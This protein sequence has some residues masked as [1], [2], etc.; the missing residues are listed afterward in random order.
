MKRFQ[1]GASV[2]EYAIL[3][4][5]VAI[6][7]LVGVSHMGS[8]TRGIFIAVNS[9]LPDLLP[10]SS[11]APTPPPAEEAVVDP[12]P[13]KSDFYRIAASGAPAYH[14]GIGGR[15]N[16]G[17]QTH[18]G[19]GLFL[20][21]NGGDSATNLAQAS[22]ILV[23]P[24]L[25]SERNLSALGSINFL[26]GGRQ[27]VVN[28]PSGYAG[29]PA[30]RMLIAQNPRDLVGK[31]AH[32]VGWPMVT[33]G[34]RIGTLWGSSGGILGSS[35]TNIVADTNVATG[36]GASVLQVEMHVAGLGLGRWAVG[37]LDSMTGALIA[38]NARPEGFP[39]VPFTYTRGN[40]TPLNMQRYQ[41]LVQQTGLHW[42][43]KNYD[44]MPAP[45]LLGAQT[46]A[47]SGPLLGTVWS[48]H[49]VA[50]L[51][52][53][54][55]APNGGQD[56]LHIA[57]AA[58][59]TTIVLPTAPGRVDVTGYR[60][61]TDRLVAPAGLDPAS[62]AQSTQ[63]STRVLSYTVNGGNVVITLPGLGSINVTVTPDV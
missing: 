61:A 43:S 40:Y 7:S 39:A 5:L 57:P 38:T 33:P 15:A 54:R 47:A 11:Q 4:G 56:N 20:S 55:V 53:G 24:G 30:L 8:S 45:I 10:T 28:V 17:V 58:G 13:E 31:Q 12:E 21:F 29:T 37:S 34:D 6:L 27:R 59:S 49:I 18:L 1:K 3:L 44:D 2:L 41:A 14:R 46:A 48:E 52:G 36:H 25:S 9:A 16:Q 22:T 63:G 35:V 51:S 62:V 60:N 42:S 26:S 50:P 19:A 23:D 32:H